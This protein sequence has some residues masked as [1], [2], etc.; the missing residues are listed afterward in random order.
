MVQHSLEF[1]IF[2][3]YAFYGFF[4]YVVIAYGVD[5]FGFPL[6]STEMEKNQ[7]QYDLC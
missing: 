4:I 2:Y 3:V 6:M 5:F 7:L 1:E